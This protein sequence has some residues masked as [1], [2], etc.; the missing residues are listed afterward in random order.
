[1]QERRTSSNWPGRINARKRSTVLASRILHE[2]TSK[3][4]VLVVVVRV[5]SFR[6]VP[7]RPPRNLSV[8]CVKI[9]ARIAR[10]AELAPDSYSTGGA[11][12]GPRSFSSFAPTASTSSSSHGRPTIC[13]PIGRPSFEKLI[14]TTAAG[15]PSRL[16]H[17]Q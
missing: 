2:D 17:S 13:T 1:M 15:K 16:N 3:L 14:G 9:F 4:S 10:K 7:L 8:L 12:Q 5:E 11:C 6:R